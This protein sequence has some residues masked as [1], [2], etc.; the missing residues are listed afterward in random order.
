MNSLR[1][2]RLSLLLLMLLLLSGCYGGIENGSV[3]DGTDTSEK[4][5]SISW[6]GDEI[7]NEYTQELLDQYEQLH[8]GIRFLPVPLG[9]EDYGEYL[10]VTAA[11]GEC[12][13]IMLMDDEFLETYAG[14]GTL[15][16]CRNLFMENSKETGFFLDS[17][18]WELGKKEGIQAGIPVSLTM[19]VLYCRP[20]KLEEAGVE[21]KKDMDWD[22]LAQ[23]SRSFQKKTG[24]P[25]IV[26]GHES[27]ELLVSW[28]EP[29]DAPLFEEGRVNLNQDSKNKLTSFF[30]LCG[31]LMKSGGMTPPE[32]PEP[33]G[34]TQE[35]E[36]EEKEGA[37]YLGDAEEHRMSKED[38]D[39]EVLLLSGG[40]PKA[41]LFFALSA[42]LTQDEKKAAA[43]FLIWLLDDEYAVE[44]AGLERGIPASE[45][46]RRLLEES[47]KLSAADK[48]LLQLYRKTQE[49]TPGFE[50]E[51]EKRKDIDRI[52]QEV[53]YKLY[54]GS[55]SPGRAADVFYQDVQE[56][57]TEQEATDES[58]GK[59]G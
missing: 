42:A 15:A 47:E 43:D 46:A 23:A 45:K 2:K 50:K 49:R 3:V 52:Y 10:A 59:A 39:M 56:L 17:E 32:N 13:D 31:E 57:F 30:S 11:A 54:Q 33:E 58:I 5:I 40:Q 41:D 21:L 19:P 18:I 24:G 6:W 34:I 27:S 22:D 55:C 14:N 26:C 44:R 25:G 20:G 51:P 29:N 8:P 53:I 28:M 12:P 9:K 7:R 48:S 1:K 35:T 36:K 16:D 37:F 38:D 4:E